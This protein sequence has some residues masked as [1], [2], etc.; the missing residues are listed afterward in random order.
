MKCARCNFE[1]QVKKKTQRFCSVN[2]ANR[3]RPIDP[4]TTR[5]RSVKRFGVIQLEHRAVMESALG[6]SLRRQEVVHHKNGNKLDNRIENLELMSP[7]DHAKHHRPQIHPTTK[8]CKLCGAVFTPHP[9][10]RLRQKACTR[11]L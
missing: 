7:S 9:T 8:S 11:K 2:C 4:V 10:K 1:M 5:Y 3:G 6:R